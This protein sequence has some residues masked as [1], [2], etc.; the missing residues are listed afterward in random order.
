[1]CKTNNMENFKITNEYNW[2]LRVLN[3][4]VN[5]SQVESSQN[6]MN[7]FMN[8]WKKTLTEE[9]KESYNYNFTSHKLAQ[10]LMIRK[11]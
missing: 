8:K 9:D 6:L 10:L 2:V 4:C 1:M 7:N 5:V 3:S 11:K